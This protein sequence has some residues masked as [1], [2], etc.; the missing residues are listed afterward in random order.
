MGEEG[1]VTKGPPVGYV[2]DDGVRG[3]PRPTYDLLEWGRRYHEDNRHLAEDH[4]EGGVRVSTVFLGIDHSFSSGGP[5]VLY[6]TMI[7]GGEH[8]GWQD[9]HTH[10][11]DALNRHRGVVKAL[12]GGKPLE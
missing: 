2:L 10:W 11:A 12:R 1:N 6:E 8:D 4:L 9:R 5:P 7:F 3:E